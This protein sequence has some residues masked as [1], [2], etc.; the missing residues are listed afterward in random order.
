MLRGKE[1]SNCFNPT[2]QLWTC[3]HL[4]EFRK[5]LEFNLKAEAS[6]CLWERQRY[7]KTPVWTVYAA[8]RDLWQVSSNR[9]T[10]TLILS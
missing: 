4:L 6:V 2:P 9:P 3:Q 10:E 7:L 1:A 5:W 8:G